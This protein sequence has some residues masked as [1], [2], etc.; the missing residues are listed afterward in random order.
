MPD[1]FAALEKV[2]ARFSEPEVQ[3][4]LKGFSRTM[5]IILTDVK[6][7]YFITI[8]NG[9]E[10]YLERGN[11]P[12]PDILIKTNSNTLAKLVS[13]SI[14]PAAAYFA[15]KITIKASMDDMLKLR[16]VFG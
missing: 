12:T 9:K 10:A 3:K 1:N 6:E 5:M 2:V 16:K 14:N 15:R 7:E 13:K 4:S 11:I 8:K